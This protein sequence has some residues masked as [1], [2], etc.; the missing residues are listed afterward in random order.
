LEKQYWRFY[1][2]LSLTGL[3]MLLARQFQNGTLARYPDAVAEL[4]TF[5]FASSTFML[6]NASLAF[7]PQMANVFA[8]SRRGKKVCFRFLLLL[9]GMLTIPVTFLALAP[10]GRHLIGRIFEIDGKVLSSVVQYLRYLLPLI[11]IRGL[12]H[13]YTGL[14]IQAKRTGYV[15]LLNVLYLATVILVLMTGVYLGWGAVKTLAFAQV[16]S[17]LVQVVLSFALYLRFWDLPDVPEHENLTYRELFAFYWPV[18]ITS[19]MFALSRPIIYA[20]LGRMPDGT[21]TIAAVRVTFDFAMI[22]HSAM[23]QFRHLFVTFGREHLPDLRR[24]MVRVLIAVMLLMVL[25]A[26]TPLSKFVFHDLLGIDGD[27]LAMA[28][29]LIWVLCLVPLIVSVRN[30]FHGIRLIG[31]RTRAMAA[32]AIARNLTICLLAWPMQS[33]GWLGHWAAG[34]ILVAGFAAETAVMLLSELN[35]PTLGAPQNVEPENGSAS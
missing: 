21:A 19:T 25:V 6:F 1:W 22:F 35:G 10:A 34:G 30:Y 2:P 29:Q 8:R 13:Y 28:R 11:F 33:E 4:A 26:A 15:T 3:A 24:F 20:F 23:N 12:R 31:R 9:C 27:V 18:A 7:I 16:W 17:G 5:A 14:L 32:A